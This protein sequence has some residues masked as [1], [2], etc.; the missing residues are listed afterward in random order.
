MKAATRLGLHL[1]VLT[2]AGSVVERE[3]VHHPGAEEAPPE[4]EVLRSL[5]HRPAALLARLSA[6][7][8]AEQSRA[9][10]RFWLTPR[11]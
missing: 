8:G 4:E 11:R 6:R 5:L 7:T 1:G 9:G 2:E 3:V 10:Q